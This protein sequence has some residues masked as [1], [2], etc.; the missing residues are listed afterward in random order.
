MTSPKPPLFIAPTFTGRVFFDMDGV[1][2]DFDAGARKL[3]LPSTQAKLQPGLYR[4]LPMIPQ[5]VL[6]AYALLKSGVDVW[7][8]TKIP[9]ENPFGAT[10]KLQW[11]ADCMPAFVKRTIITPHK[12]MLSTSEDDVLIDDRPHKAS[13]D[14]FGGFVIPLLSTTCPSWAEAE[15]LLCDYLALDTPSERATFRLTHG[16]QKATT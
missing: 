13:I 5:G 10:E 6:M 15:P 4:H 12:G 1:L 3:G 11:I 2:A 14:E 7:I 9:H 8:A 16:W